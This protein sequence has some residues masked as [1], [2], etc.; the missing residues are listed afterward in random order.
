MSMESDEDLR[1]Q[2]ETDAIAEIDEYCAQQ[3]EI[4]EK[5]NDSGDAYSH[6]P[7]EGDTLDME[8][9]LVTFCKEAGIET[10]DLEP[11]EILEEALEGFRMEPGTIYERDDGALFVLDAYPV[12]EVQISLQSLDIDYDLI[13]RIANRLDA[14]ISRDGM[15]YMSSDAVWRAVIDRETLQERLNDVL[16]ARHAAVP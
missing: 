4:A 3:L 2:V 12:G 8:R 13:H 5:A 14:T 9:R 16:S 10:G 7:R 1:E 11:D 6:M 15:A